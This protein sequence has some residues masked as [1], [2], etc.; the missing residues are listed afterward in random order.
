MAAAADEPVN[1][2]EGY[3]VRVVTAPDEGKVA[4]GGKYWRLVYVRHRTP[5]ENQG[6]HN[7]YVTAMDEN[8]QRVHDDGLR[9]GWTWEGRK[10]DEPVE[11]KR[12]DKPDNEPAGNVDIYGG[13]HLAVW[14]MGDGLA[15]DRAENL[16]THHPDEPGPHGELWN[17]IGH[18]S[19]D[20]VFQ[21]ST[22]GEGDAGGGDAGG[23]DAGGGDGER[24]WLDARYVG[25]AIVDLTMVRP[26][27]PFVQTWTL[28]NRGT[29][30]W[31]EGGALVRT[32]GEVMG[33]PAAVALPPTDPGEQ[34]SVSVPFVAPL[35]AG[36][37]TSTWQPADA[38]GTRFGDPVWVTV[39]V[40]ERMI[41]LPN[42]QTGLRPAQA[43]AFDG[44]PEGTVAT[45]LPAQMVR[46]FAKLGLDVNAPI[47][48][49][50]GLVA[51]QVSDPAIAAE[52][53]VGWVRIN[54]ILGQQ[55]RHPL[56][57][58]R[59]QGMTWAETYR[60]ILDGFR[61]R[62]LRIYALLGHEA[63]AEDPGDR[64][65]DAPGADPLADPWVQQYAGN[66]L[67]I[68]QLFREL[69]EVIETFNEPDDWHGRDRNWIHP[70][71]L[72]AMLEAVYRAVRS[73][74]GLAHLRIVSG[75]LQGLQGEGKSNGA[76]DYL[77]RVYQAGIGMF[78]WGRDGRPFPFDGVGY[79]LYVHEN[80]TDNMDQQALDLDNTYRAYLAQ[81]LDVVRRQE[82]VDKPLYVSEAG[83]FSNGGNREFCERFQA[84]SLQLGIN[85]LLAEPAVAL[86]F[87]FC[88]QD[89]GGPNDGKF[90]GIYRAGDLGVQNRKPA[91]DALRAVAASPNL[92]PTSERPPIYDSARYVAGKDAVADETPFAPGVAFQQVWFLAN[93]G[94]T[95]WGPG[96][97]LVCVGGDRIGAPERVT[98][99]A[100]APGQETAVAVAHVAPAE[101]GRY[102]SVWQPANAQG[103]LFGQRVWTIINVVPVPAGAAFPRDGQWLP[104]AGGAPVTA[105]TGGHAGSGTGTGASTVRPTRNL[106]DSLRWLVRLGVIYEGALETLPA[107]GDAEAV[108]LAVDAAVAEARRRLKELL[109]E[110]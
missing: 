79:H 67:A 14:I 25:E 28:E 55:W 13:M 50:S 61:S 20:L 27:Q 77:D 64:F 68:A 9:I 26:A 72:A 45:S 69:I 19:F 81:M 2:A 108:A 8:G 62:G 7:A 3:D 36:S 90:Y 12:L 96:Y 47:D 83:W 56:D 41:Y 57:D 104:M 22:V 24:K 71:W 48:S 102:T 33:S 54:M 34:A 38:E 92:V 100:C 94:T 97:S 107:S 30:R 17:S 91:Y 89:F 21:R 86:V 6:K 76:A 53:G 110:P 40:A 4:P 84:G 101:P 32:G 39:F 43:P 103:Q 98:L 66:V 60:F 88:L 70:G 49:A 15:S 11:P 16:H 5:E 59:P 63:V 109:S 74:A 44:V 65:R 1:Q 18:H 31:P 46:P 87:A 52:T 82:G 10:E 99:P 106:Q 37:Y 73:D 23:G 85:R 95:T 58:K 75:P 105:H 93:D 51:S 42:V 80:A 29:Q 35:V 78:G